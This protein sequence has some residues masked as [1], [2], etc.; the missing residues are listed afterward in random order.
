MTLATHRRIAGRKY[1]RLI[2]TLMLVAVAFSIIGVTWTRDVTA[3]EPTD[4]S[5]HAVDQHVHA[6]AD[7]SATAS[8]PDRTG[9]EYA[10]N[11]PWKVRP[12]FKR[13][14]GAPAAVRGQQCPAWVHDRYV[15]LGPDG[16]FYPKWHAPVDTEYGCFFGHEHG[17]NPTASPALRGWKVLFGYAGHRIG[18]IH[19][20]IVEAHSGYK[21]HRVDQLR[22]QT[23]GDSTHN[24]ASLLVV[25]HQG[26]TTANA[27]T[28]FL[29]EV[30]YN[31]YNP[32]D[33]REVHT[34]LMAEF[35]DLAIRDCSAPGKET[36]VTQGNG[37][38]RGK[39][40]IPGAN[41]VVGEQFPSGKQYED[42]ITGIYVGHNGNYA[43][44]KA[45]FDPHFAIFN[46]ARFC[47]LQSDRTCKHAYTADYIG[48]DDPTSRS[49][50]FKGDHREIYTNAVNIDN[51]GGSTEIW[52]DAM[53]RSVS[54]STPGAIKQFVAAI[55]YEQY[56]VGSIVNG[57][58]K[59]YDQN[60]TV[61]LPN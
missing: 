5:P 50:R 36:I 9:Y 21:I 41:C 1:L 20:G 40:S 55:D 12:R 53:G 59:Y 31:Y 33:G 49:S 44:A 28:Q 15:N 42:W 37:S 48:S 4:E 39:R 25:F 60:G 7:T 61:T 8:G 13:P 51:A 17:D 22:D 56:R 14:A 26:S 58:D 2:S 46:P 52:T 24:G 54:K 18:H 47:T 16:L 30:D 29:H 19:S 35:N 3:A 43:G 27:F 10:R 45:Y 11:A 6:D 32:R 57:A 34:Y 23:T 38:H